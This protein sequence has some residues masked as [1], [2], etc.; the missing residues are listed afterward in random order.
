MSQDPTSDAAAGAWARRPPS[1]RLLQSNYQAG[2]GSLH[3]GSAP[4]AM[5]K[6][7]HRTVSDTQN[8]A[9]AAPPV[10]PAVAAAPRQKLSLLKEN[11]ASA[12]QRVS[13]RRKLT[14]SSVESHRSR[15]HIARPARRVH[16]R[17]AWRQNSGCVRDV[18]RRPEHIPRARVA[19]Q[20]SEHNLKERGKR[21]DATARRSRPP[22]ALRALAPCQ[23]CNGP[24]P[25]PPAT[26]RI[27]RRSP[28]RLAPCRAGTWAAR[29]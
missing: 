1:W 5:G 27:P 11:A 13:N 9:E 28:L 12:F 19:V 29:A 3:S 25:A 23:R 16:A 17:E 4:A 6:M 22:K 24:A 8:C 18:Q 15:M 2:T 21:S 20:R 26:A 14:P 7:R 10:A